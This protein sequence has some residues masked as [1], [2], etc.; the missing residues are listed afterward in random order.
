MTTWYSYIT[1]SK[2]QVFIAQLAPCEC[3]LNLDLKNTIY[4]KIENYVLK[5]NPRQHY[6]WMEDIFYG[7]LIILQLPGS[8]RA[9]IVNYTKELTLKLSCIPNLNYDMPERGTVNKIDF[10]IKKGT[11]SQIYN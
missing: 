8:A 1:L 6:R 5:P 7:R 9:S 2:N 3:K 10:E 11:I 4:F